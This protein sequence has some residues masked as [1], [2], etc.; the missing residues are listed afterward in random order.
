M[1]DEKLDEASSSYTYF[2]EYYANDQG[3]IQ[4]KEATTIQRH[5]DRV[6]EN[7]YTRMG[8]FNYERTRQLVDFELKAEFKELEEN[9]KP[10]EKDL[11]WR[12]T[13]QTG[14]KYLLNISEYLS[15]KENAFKFSLNYVA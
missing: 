4:E 5:L 3:Y 2:F 8:K 11:L 13:A 15:N 14:I 10:K 6:F 7:R 12:D 1:D 9:W